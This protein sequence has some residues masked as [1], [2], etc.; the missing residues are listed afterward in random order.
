MIRQLKK[1]GPLQPYAAL[2]NSLLLSMCDL[3]MEMKGKITISF[4]LKRLIGKVSAYLGY[5]SSLHFSIKP[6]DLS[7]PESLEFYGRGSASCMILVRQRDFHT[8]QTLLQRANVFLR[9][10][11]YSAHHRLNMELDLQSLFGLLCTAVLIG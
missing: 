9:T 5:N 10:V 2:Y 8:I 4:I 6:A 7:K 1:C 3:C 11:Q